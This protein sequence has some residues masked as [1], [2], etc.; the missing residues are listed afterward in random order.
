[1]TLAKRIDAALRAVPCRNCG[2]LH[3]GEKA[4]DPRPLVWELHDFQP[5]Y[6]ALTAAV[7][8]VVEDMQ[9]SWRKEALEQNRKRG[10][11]VARV[12]ELEGHIHAWAQALRDENMH[13][14]ADII[15]AVLARQPETP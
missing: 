8:G 12:R 9:E 13:R 6:P 10:A 7:L 1:M 14:S 4:A 3:Y 15:S 11:E 2:V 5:D